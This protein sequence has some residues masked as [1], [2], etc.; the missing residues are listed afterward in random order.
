MQN[1]ITH[2][3]DSELEHIKLALKGEDPVI[4]Q[5]ILSDAEEF[6]F[7]SVKGMKNPSDQDVKKARDRFGNPRAIA[8]TYKGELTSSPKLEGTAFVTVKQFLSVLIRPEGYFRVVFLVY[9]IV[10]AL[11]YFV[12]A[13]AG[14][15]LSLAAGVLTVGLPLTILYFYMVRVLAVA[16]GRV[17]QGLTGEQMPKRPPFRRPVTTLIDGMKRGLKDPR[18]WSSLLYLVLI[19]PLGMA[20]LVGLVGGIGSGLSLISWPLLQWQFG[21]SPLNYNGP[22]ELP[23]YVLLLAPFAGVAILAVVLHLAGFAAKFHAGLAK[24]LL[25]RIP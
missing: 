19:L 2:L 12:F 4:V 1:N 9:V 18:T 8:K 20:Y 25:V 11:P 23:F 3:I 7:E 10:V 17:I 21:I 15:L 14:L 24:A 16:E 22:V 13:T 6:L 5:D